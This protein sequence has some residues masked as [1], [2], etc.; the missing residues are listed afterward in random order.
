MA[1]T[2][3]EFTKRY[4]ERSGITQDELAELGLVASPCDC[5]D[6]S[7]KGW[8]MTSAADIERFGGAE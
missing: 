2:K 8:Q 5:G 1:I 6:R 3:E 4:C 7:C